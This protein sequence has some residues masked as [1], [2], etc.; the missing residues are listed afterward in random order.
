[1]VISLESYFKVIV[2]GLLAVFLTGCS[3]ESLESDNSPVGI[4]NPASVNCINQGGKLTLENSS[5]GEYGV[6]T[7]EDNRKCEEWALMR[8]QCPKGG[9][10]VTGYATKA[11]EY[12]AITGGTYRVTGRSNTSQEQGSCTFHSGKV[13]GAEA[14]YQGKCSRHR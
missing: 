1:M 4:P 8:G 10:K 14:Y 6:C 11:A 7:F 5:S 3:S 12:C 13:C 9:L 2:V